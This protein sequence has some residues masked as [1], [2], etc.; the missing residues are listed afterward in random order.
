MGISSKDLVGTPDICID[1]RIGDVVKD[2]TSQSRHYG[3]LELIA[4]EE[5][6]FAC[7]RSQS[8]QMPLSLEVPER[9]L[10]HA[11]CH[12][13]RA[14][15]RVARDKVK[16]HAMIVDRDPRTDHA[17]VPRQHRRRR[18]PWQEIRIMLG[19]LDQIEHPPDRV[20]EE[21]GFPDFVHVTPRRVPWS[22]SLGEG[23]WRPMY[24]NAS[25]PGVLS[26]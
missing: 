24:A 12:E 22:S 6:D 25:T 19:G 18:A 20:S 2:R 16:S 17:L 14:A 7:R 23:R 1:Q 13:F 5:L 8:C 4:Q 26:C 21:G 10:L 9:P 3:A 11:D 15:L